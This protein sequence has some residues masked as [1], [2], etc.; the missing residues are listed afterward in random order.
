ML[1][2]LTVAIPPQSNRHTIPAQTR[3]PLKARQPR[4]LPPVPT[5]QPILET[6]PAILP[7]ILILMMGLLFGSFL[8]VCIARLPRRESIVH[9]PSH[10]PHCG[11]PIHPRDN[12]PVLS[13]LILR[14]RC[15]TCRQ[16]ISWRYP[17]VELA[18][19]LLWLLCFLQFGLTLQAAA[20]ATLCFLA[21]GLAIMDAETMLLPDAFTLSGIALGVLWSALS[22][23]HAWPKML[24]AAGIS[25]LWAAAAAGI[26]LLIRTAYWLIRRREGMGLGD[27]KLFAMFAAWL[28]PENALL[29]FF[30]A[31]LTGA[32]Y[33]VLILRRQSATRARVPPR[34]PLGSFLCTATLYA[35]FAGARTIDWY[36]G[37][38]R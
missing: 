30:L 26:M 29:I 13:Y 16:G 2:F 25:L 19:A 15:R 9:P 34:V 8:N 1:E 31:V 20:M 18:N 27:V 23:G 17:A 22:T 33:G 4:I 37:F 6:L 28:G 5:T 14:G 38:F 3:P 21:L 24:R 35:I 11:T 7:S 12:I 36:L 32:A 10:C